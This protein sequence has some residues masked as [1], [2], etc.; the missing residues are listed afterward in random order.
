M[1]DF[2]RIRSCYRGFNEDSRLAASAG[3]QMEYAMKQLL[4]YL[5]QQAEVLDPGGAAGTH[6][7]PLAAQGWRMHLADL[8]PRLIAQ[9]R[10]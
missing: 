2:E 8:S 10:E 1:T 6:T 9:A 4:K 7:F 5:P 3:G